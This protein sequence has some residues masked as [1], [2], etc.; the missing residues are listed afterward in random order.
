MVDQRNAVF[1][2]N[3]LAGL[4]GVSGVS[5]TLPV[6]VRNR[7]EREYDSVWLT[8]QNMSKIPRISH[9]T[10]KK[11]VCLRLLFCDPLWQGQSLVTMGHSEQFRDKE[12]KKWSNFLSHPLR[13]LCF[14][15]SV[16]LQNNSKSAPTDLRV[17]FKQR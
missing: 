8:S 4:S 6:E 1:I 3:L 2:Q 14:R 9:A 11:I 13:R 10:V 12:K 7:G 17:T 16:C 15:L 5:V